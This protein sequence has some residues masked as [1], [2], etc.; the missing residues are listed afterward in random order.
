MRIGKHD[1]GQK[2]IIIAEIGNN[3]EG[4]FPLAQEMLALAAEAGADIIKFQTFRVERFCTPKLPERFAQLQK[5]ALSFEQFANLS[6]Q[7]EA[8]G[9]TFLSTPFDLESAAFLAGVAPGFKIASGDNDYT[10][11]LELIAGT[12]KPTILSTGMSDLAQIKDSVGTLEHTWAAKGLRRSDCLALLHCVSAYPAPPG[13]VNLR[14]IPLLQQ[15][16]P[17]VTIGYS[18]H[19]LGIEACVAAVACGARIVEK[20]FTKSKTLSA[21]RDHQLSADPADMRSLVHRIR[22][23]ELM[24]G[25]PEKK[26][27]EPEKGVERAAR[28]SVI[29]TRGLPAGHT[30]APEDL[31]SMRAEAPGLRA[32]WE[33][34][35]VGRILKR[36]LPEWAIIQSED[37]RE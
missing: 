32:P 12:G 8:L 34:K 20:H 17:D 4:N 31:I 7:A 16:F 13:E 5:Y 26:V 18:D 36:G 1:S 2:V 29:T 35:L 3:H 28:R 19:A 21:F 23:T 15:T 24:L 27:L 25:K 14:A 11:L 6:R 22:E 37:L 33:P 30:L 10:K 9:A